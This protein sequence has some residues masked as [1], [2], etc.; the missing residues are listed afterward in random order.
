MEKNYTS[1]RDDK[2]KISAK[3]AIK[4]GFAD[5]GG[6]FVYPQ[7]NQLKVDLKSL[8]T[9]GYQ[10]IAQV[11]LEKLLP[12]FTKVEIHSSIL[13]AYGNN[14]DNKNIT[15]VVDVDDFHVLEL[16]HGPT[17]AFKD[18]GLQ[19]LP[20]LMQRVLDDDTKVMILTATSGDT[21]KAAL[22][23][24]KNVEQTG[25]TVFY[26]YQGV[27]PIQ[28]L[29]METTDG[30]NTDI[31][32][33]K[34]NFDDAQTNVKQIF[35]DQAFKKSLG[36]KISLSSANSINIG[37]LIPQVVYYF[38]SY[39]QLVNKKTLKLG[40]K[41]NFTVPTG[42]FGDVL[43]GYYAKQ[44]GLP[45]NK[46]IVASNE[47]NVLTKFFK[48]GIYDRNMPFYQTIAP[49]MDIQISSNFERL[50]YYKSGEDT[51]YVQK[52]MT[53]LE[54]TGRYRVCDK[55]LS[56]IKED[57]FCA[58]STDEEIKT[59][60]NSLFKK[61]NYLMDPHTAVGYKAMRD[62]QKIHDQTPNILLSTASPYKFVHAVSEAILKH[63]AEDDQEAMQQLEEIS[64]VPIPR[65]L[66]NLFDLP[67]LHHDIIETNNMENYIKA[68]VEEKFYDKNQS[69][70]N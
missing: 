21:G 46:F 65:N 5:D 30:N 69:A 59:S 61:S 58:Y 25:I 53:E 28:Q 41:V 68:K 47:N 62:Y 19:M 51:A 42:N 50:L 48:T 54:Q 23:G 32:A 64:Q 20:Q 12:D 45:V 60:I 6:L 2:I 1:T 37:R 67:I 16:F 13:N 39:I 38:A 27:S 11:I 57:F 29:Q 66:K 3:D 8:V 17:S 33:I 31:T 34:G 63:P 40:Q 35:N 49:S 43:A 7:L 52:L 4:K 44:M 22:V 10:S 24:F 36:D 9:M 70:S 55:V 26:P 18:I 14:F 15:P 56:A